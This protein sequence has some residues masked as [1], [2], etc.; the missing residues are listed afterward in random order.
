M[1]PFQQQVIDTTLAEF[2]RNRAIQEQRL[3]INKQAGVLG[4]G[5]AGVQLAEFQT[6]QTEIVQHYKHSFYLWFWSSTSKQHNKH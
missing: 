4:A 1:S 6:G 2:D 5:R 3:E